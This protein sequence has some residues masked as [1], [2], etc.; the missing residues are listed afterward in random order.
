ML[1]EEK[2]FKNSTMGSKV[3]LSHPGDN[4]G[5]AIKGEIEGS[6]G[7]MQFHILVM[8]NKKTKK[9]LYQENSNVT[10][11]SNRLL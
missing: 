2:G 7:Y 4:G 11:V 6:Q 3:K 9:G 1:K 8:G 5:G 10:H